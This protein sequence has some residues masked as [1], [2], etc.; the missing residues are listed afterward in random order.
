MGTMRSAG[1]LKSLARPSRLCSRRY[2]GPTFC[3]KDRPQAKHGHPGRFCTDG[4]GSQAGP[5][6]VAA[7]TLDCL[8]R[9]VPAAIPGVVF[10]SG[11]QTPDAATSHLDEIV[12]QGGGILPWSV[13]FSY[14]RAL[15]QEALAA[16]RGNAANRAQAQAAFRRRCDLVAAA[17][18]GELVTA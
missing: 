1:A 10:L 9:A 7:A 16:W 12:R 2:T 3:W 13:S 5:Q 11:G 4:D 17:A 6:A 15:Q 8:R 18:R 14:A